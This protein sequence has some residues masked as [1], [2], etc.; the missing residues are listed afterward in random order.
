MS[1]CFPGILAA[2]AD[3]AVCLR[4]QRQQPPE[5]QLHSPPGLDGLVSLLASHGDHEFLGNASLY[6]L[7]PKQAALGFEHSALAQ[8]GRLR[9]PY[10]SHRERADDVSG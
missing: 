6:W 4:F 3:L 10:R 9:L 1:G 8:S 2:K 5:A 7:R